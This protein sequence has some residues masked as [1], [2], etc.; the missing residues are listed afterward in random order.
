MKLLLLF[1]ALLSTGAAHGQIIGKVLPD[2]YTSKL[3]TPVH[4]GDS[5]HFTMGQRED[6]SFRYAEIGPNMLSPL[7]MG[8]PKAWNNKAGVVKE[9]RGFGATRIVVFKAGF[10]NA[11]LDFDSAEKSGEISTPNNQKKATPTTAGVADE[12]IK[13]KALLDAGALT[14]AEF[15]V[16]KTKLLSR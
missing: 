9:V 2:G 14:Q 7:T 16:Q 11:T 8:L 13:L 12:L 3:G 6:G 5:I 15:D 4:R 1:A 10:Y